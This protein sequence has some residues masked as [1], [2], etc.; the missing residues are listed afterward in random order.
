MYY[1]LQIKLLKKIN[2]LINVKKWK[3]K[4]ANKLPILLLI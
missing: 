2:K 1:F 4:I 3:Q